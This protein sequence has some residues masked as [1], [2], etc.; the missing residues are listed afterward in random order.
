M[1]SRRRYISKDSTV[2]K[3]FSLSRKIYSL[4]QLNALLTKPAELL[5]GATQRLPCWPVINPLNYRVKKKTRE[6]PFLFSPPLNN[7]PFNLQPRK[8]VSP[9]SLAA[10]FPGK[11]MEGH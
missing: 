5:S 1:E 11:I 10:L 9:L 7:D 4:H 6:K 2:A 3:H 8:V